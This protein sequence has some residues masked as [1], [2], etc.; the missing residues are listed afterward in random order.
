[1]DM[2]LDERRDNQLLLRRYRRRQPS[3]RGLAV[4]L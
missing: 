1:M 4:M 2:R 3:A